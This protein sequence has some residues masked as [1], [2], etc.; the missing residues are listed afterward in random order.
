MTSYDACLSLGTDGSLPSSS[1][2]KSQSGTDQL[3]VAIP[4]AEEPDKDKAAACKRQVRKKV[5]ND[6]RFR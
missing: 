2:V 1:T 6:Q 4:V 5:V 3:K